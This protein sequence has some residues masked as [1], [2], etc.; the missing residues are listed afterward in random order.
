[1]S[2]KEII[3]YVFDEHKK[4]QNR[5]ECIHQKNLQSKKEFEE[6]YKETQERIKKAQERIDSYSK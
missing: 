3:K 1:M 5:I 4:S 6:H 2:I